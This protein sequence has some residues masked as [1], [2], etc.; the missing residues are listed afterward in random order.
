[1]SLLNH[2]QVCVKETLKIYSDILEGIQ[3]ESWLNYLF[4]SS[5][6][7]PAVSSVK[8]WYGTLKQVTKSPLQIFTIYNSWLSSHVIVYICITSFCQIMISLCNWSHAYDKTENYNRINQSIQK[9]SKLLT[10][11]KKWWLLQTSVLKA[12]GWV[13]LTYTVRTKCESYILQNCM[14][15][16]YKKTYYISHVRVTHANSV[17]V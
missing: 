4:P 11:W 6:L 9:P 7:S 12:K 13:I 8:C 10:T 3:S 16:S 14:L 2:E 15:S 1:M 17:A 5:F